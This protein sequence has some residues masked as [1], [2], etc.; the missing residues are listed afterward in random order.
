MAN[1]GYQ[2]TPTLIQ[3]FLDGPESGS[4]VTGSFGKYENQL[5]V[6]PFSA[7]IEDTNYYYRALNEV[8]CPEG[9]EDCQAPVLTSVQT[10]SAKGLFNLNYT[11]PNTLNAAIDITGSISQLED[12][13]VVQTFSAS[14]GS[15]LP[16]SSSFT[17]GTVYF[18]AFQS[19]S[20]PDKSPF[21]DPLEFTFA[22]IPPPKPPGVLRY[23][24]QNTL[25]TPITLN[26]R[27]TRG[28]FDQNVNAGATFQSTFL[29]SNKSLDI[30]FKG[31][32]NTTY[33][34][35]IIKNISTTGGAVASS[36]YVSSPNNGSGF[37]GSRGGAITFYDGKAKVNFKPVNTP[38]PDGIVDINLTFASN[39][40]PAPPVAP[41][42]PTPT[43]PVPYTPRPTIRFG[44]SAFSTADSACNSTDFRSQTY[45]QLGNYLYL[46]SN[47]AIAGNRPS[48][49][50]SRNYIL[51]NTAQHAVV[52]K[53]GYI[54]ESSN[55]CSYPT[56][57][58]SKKSYSNQEAACR[59]RAFS[60]QTVQYKGSQ[61]IGSGLTGRFKM[62]TGRGG[63]NVILSSG[64]IISYETC[65]TEGSSVTYT[66]ASASV[67]GAT[68][69]DNPYWSNFWCK[70][71]TFRTYFVGPSGTTYYSSSGKYAY[72]PLGLGS[73]IHFDSNKNGYIF[74]KGQITGTYNLSC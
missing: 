52:S 74:F 13:S 71:A 48:F 40:P 12:F 27:S 57:T 3:R 33:G 66:R 32:S 2:I 23:K 18:R 36:V 28:N 43:N 62:Q 8:T 68:S 1:T 73:R 31:G 37:N 72:I 54:I 9:F 61:L 10:G 16:I 17:S 25:N 22:P 70:Y 4:I 6:A 26:V 30:N 34:N 35:T 65:G 69:P 24:V 21:S 55:T 20:G 45:Y 50:N 39:T 60:T 5:G 64:R 14:I 58:I 11:Q 38:P 19:C 42:P 53:N 15:M 7:S 67:S 47:D 51:T 56:L 29:A 59:D 63:Q 41:S 49:P 44:G 46:T